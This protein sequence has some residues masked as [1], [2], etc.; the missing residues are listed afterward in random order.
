M[1]RPRPKVYK[2]P[3]IVAVP[4][5]ARLI[6]IQRSLAY[7]L[8]AAGRWGSI[9]PGRPRRVDWNIVLRWDAARNRTRRWHSIQRRKPY[10]LASPHSQR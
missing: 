7:R 10:D 8:A 9:Y 5:A 6:G 2:F 1:K 3:T 4:E